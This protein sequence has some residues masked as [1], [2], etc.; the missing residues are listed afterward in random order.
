LYSAIEREC[1]GVG[2]VRESRGFHPHLTIARIRQPKGAADLARLHL[3]LGFAPISFLVNEFVLFKSDIGST[4]SSFTTL[5]HHIF[6][7][8]SIE[9]S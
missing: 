4:G 5:S 3:S 6:R 1:E 2:F 7:Q 9:V 8:N